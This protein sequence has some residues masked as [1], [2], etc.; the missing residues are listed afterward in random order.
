VTSG[1]GNAAL[2]RLS[3]SMSTSQ[4]FGISPAAVTSDD[5]YSA[6]VTA[7]VANA[8]TWFWCIAHQNISSSATLAT[9]LRVRI[10][11]D[12]KFFDATTISLSAVRLHPTIRP[13]AGSDITQ[14]DSSSAAAPSGTSMTTVPCSLLSSSSL[15]TVPTH[16]GASSLQKNAPQMDSG[17]DGPLPEP[18]CVICQRSEDYRF[19]VGSKL[20]ICAEC[21]KHSFCTMGGP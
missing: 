11:Y 8:Q 18:K 14:G 4:I 1:I 15:P 16:E 2:S 20:T 13:L 3:N 12:V 10:E 17:F 6:L 5:L 7:N 19:V 9:M 21:A